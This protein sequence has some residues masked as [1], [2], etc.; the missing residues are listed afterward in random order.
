MKYAVFTG[1]IGE[2]GEHRAG[3]YDTQPEARLGAYLATEDYKTG[4]PGIE[5][6][7]RDPDMIICGWEYIRVGPMGDGA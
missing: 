7:T 5:P 1:T 2:P 4:M 6:D 3:V